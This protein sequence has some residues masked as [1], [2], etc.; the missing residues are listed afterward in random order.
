MRGRPGIAARRDGA[1]R[2]KHRLARIAG[3]LLLVLALERP[4]GAAA[5]PGPPPVTAPP[6]VTPPTPSKPLVARYPRDG[7][8]EAHVIVELVVDRL[9]NVQDARVVE[10]DEP[11]AGAALRA[12]RALSFDPARRG[13]L[14]IAA[15]IRMKI[16]FTPTPEEL[17]ELPLNPYEDRGPPR[18]EIPLEALPPNPYPPPR[19]FENVEVYGQKRA[20]GKVSL[21]RTELRDIPGAFGDGFRA[22]E[23]LPGV[24][25]MASGLPFFF[26][27]GAPPGSTGY[28]LDGVRLPVLFHIGAGSS[29]VHPALIDRID[30]HPGAAPAAFGRVTGGIVAGITKDPVP[31]LHGE[32]NLRLLDAGGMVEAPLPGGRG[33]LLA[34]GRFGYPGLLLPLFAPNTRLSYWDYQSRLAID[35]GKSDRV[36]V[37]A[38]GSY[39]YLGR[40]SRSTTATVD[41]PIG[42]GEE[43][44]PSLETRTIFETEFHRVDLRHDRK[45]RDGRIRTAFTIGYD[46]SAIGLK[47]RVSAGLIGGRV[48]W[49]ERISKEFI[50]TGGMD[51]VFQHYEVSGEGDIPADVEFTTLFPSRDELTFGARG[52]VTWSPGSRAQ[53]TAG[54]RFDRYSSHRA[55][56]PESTSDS[57]KGEAF[58]LEPRVSSR[59]K[60]VPRVVLVSTA[61]LSSQPP[62]FVFPLPGLTVG[63]LGEGLERAVQTSHGV[64]WA[65]PLAFSLTTTFFSSRSIGLADIF[66]ACPGTR[67]AFTDGNACTT[68]SGGSAVGMEVYLRRAFSERLSGFLSYTLSRS[69]RTVPQTV[70]DPPPTPGTP[71][72]SV[73][74]SP[75]A[76]RRM[77]IASDYDRT[78]VLNAALAW[79]I[80]RGF[81][82]G[83]RLL[84]YS[85]RPF[86]PVDA[87]NK[88]LFGADG[89]LQV[90][91]NSLRLPLFHRFDVRLEK[92]W[93][94]GPDRYVSLVLEGLNI[95]F[96]KEA[97]GVTCGTKAGPGDIDLGYGC[98]ADEIGPIAIPSLGI[99][100][101]F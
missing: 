14:P 32:A 89:K 6:V 46:K 5:Q 72:E 78:H 20:V 39:D 61:G 101:M 41:D 23:T 28:F 45:T 69:T 85:G 16:D 35:I 37:F 36:T 68:R 88:L 15:R 84:M 21:G 27:R 79:D 62:R 77:T 42:L 59:V 11:F 4:E 12:V 10:G 49:E 33:S 67:N 96:R 75:R 98:V 87:E 60:V 40:R 34:A 91:P 19:P 3:A 97:T 8:G 7:V 31:R 44:N 74:V 26:V 38:F 55:R 22:I 95:T 2:P 51:G 50:L 70:F 76:G 18:P 86:T 9:G 94:F 82:A 81:R 63:R 71:A 58:S 47:D 57:S 54:L 93:S 48:E 30:F 64:E 100:A 56:L 99:E 66:A 90:F 17:P 92:K 43:P 80:G 1:G 83:L 13:D 73:P 29:V 52:D 25:P 24:V 65:L 53:M